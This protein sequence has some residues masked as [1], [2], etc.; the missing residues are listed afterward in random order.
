M[1]LLHCRERVRADLMQLSVFASE[2][3]RDTKK[4]VGHL[5]TTVLK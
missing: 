2:L 4:S 3:S 5:E 1:N